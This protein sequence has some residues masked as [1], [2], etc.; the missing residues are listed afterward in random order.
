M[1]Y[2][3]RLPREGERVPV[4]E[5]ETSEE[6]EGEGEREFWEE[7][8]KVEA[9]DVEGLRTFLRQRK[10]KLQQGEADAF[11]RKMRAV[12]QKRERVR[13]NRE[14]RETMKELREYQWYQNAWNEGETRLEA[15][16]V[17]MQTE[18]EKA[19]AAEVR[20]EDVKFKQAEAAAEKLLEAMSKVDLFGSDEAAELW[21]SHERAW[22]AFEAR[23]KAA[24]V[25]YEEVPWPPV[26]SGLLSAMAAA[27][28]T[29][30]K[31]GEKGTPDS[32]EAFVA[33][34]RAF[35]RAHLRWHPDKFMHRFGKALGGKDAERIRSKVQEISQA[36]NHAWSTIEGDF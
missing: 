13:L 16:K 18:E 15:T 34:K 1:E 10:G 14:R 24:P 25:S 8:C 23:E 29:R 6:E 4:W 33:H 20:S 36:I 31:G 2:G 17:R 9:V 32:K 3:P 7:V 19:W 11:Y 35:K 21:T 28:I 22:E 27:E 12:L 26:T 5:Q 30:A